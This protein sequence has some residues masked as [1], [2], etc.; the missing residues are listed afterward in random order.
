[1]RV[2]E[3]WDEGGAGALGVVERGGDAVVDEL[4]AEVHVGA[5]GPRGRHLGDR[6]RG[7]HED[8]GR[9]TGEGR[10]EGHALGV[11]ARRGGDDTGAGGGVDAGDAVVGAADL[12]AARALQVLTLEHEVTTRELAERPGDRDRRGAQDRRHARPSVA[13][14]VERDHRRRR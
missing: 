8:G 10:G 14:V 2:V 1:M 12:V 3:G 4:A 6:R 13:Q 5:V 9:E 11:V 7:R